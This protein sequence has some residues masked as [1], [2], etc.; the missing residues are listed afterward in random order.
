MVVLS[1]AYEIEKRVDEMAAVIA[2]E[3]AGKPLAIIGVATGAFLFMAYLDI[4]DTGITLSTLVAH[5]GTKDVASFSVC[6]LLDK[7]SRRTVPLQ[8]GA[9]GKY[10]RGFQCFHEFVV[11]YGMDYAEQYRCL[12]Y[13]G[14]LKLHIYTKN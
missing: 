5:F 14:V 10:Y 11:G 12:P 2:Q 1:S 6:T 3:F 13:I 7:P 9:G 4:V 8:L